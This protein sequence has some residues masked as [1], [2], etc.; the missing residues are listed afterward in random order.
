LTP[1]HSRL[2]TGDRSFEARARGQISQR[3]YTEVSATR[4]DAMSQLEQVRDSDL[5]R[6]AELANLE[7][8]D[9]EAVLLLRDLNSVLDYVAELNELDTSDLPA[10]AQVGEVLSGSP[11]A[12]TALRDD[13]IRPSLDRTAV[14]NSAP[15]SDHTF[16]L[17]PKVIER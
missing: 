13:E 2:L 14:M 9:E 1:I 15:D 17:V 6:V 11:G 16:F 5:C 10:M 7:L 3:V 12:A 4:E 8:T